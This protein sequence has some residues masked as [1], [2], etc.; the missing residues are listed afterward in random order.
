M[1]LPQG[2]QAAGMAASL[3]RSGKPDLSLITAAEPLVWAFVGTTN[4]VNAPCVSRN[5]ARSK[6]G[7]GIRAIVINSGSANCATGE[8]GA[9]D[10]EAYAQAVAEAL[11]LADAG[12]VLT[13]STGVIGQPLNVGK[14]R[15]ELPKLLEHL[16]AEADPVARAIMTTDTR[17]KLV[18][19]D[20]GGARL[21]GIAKGSGMIHPNMATMLAFLLTDADISQDTLRELWPEIV[22][23]TF[24]QV[25]VDGDTSTNDMAM[26]CSS[27]QVPTD[28]SKFAAGLE[29]VCQELARSIARDGE[30]ASKLITVNV[31]GAHT[32]AEARMA[33]RAVVKSPLVK[34]AAHGN[35]PNWGRILSAAGTSGASFNPAE[36]VI[37]VQDICVYRSAPPPQTFDAAEASRKMAGEEL[38]IDVDLGAGS[39]AGTAWG[40]D[41]TAEYVHINA[42]YHT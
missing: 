39:G 38:R 20:I 42:D 18:E 26:V 3:K 23:R 33:A 37:Y 29:Q 36:A 17:L 30:G 19:A 6:A 31:R 15:R 27:R 11:G 9:R 28:T 8:Q 34:A 22:G 1:K 5:R 7:G 41:L 32:D 13:A 21:V 25:T 12:A 24:N 35:D 2:F 4:L 14:I 16:N 10:N 40:C